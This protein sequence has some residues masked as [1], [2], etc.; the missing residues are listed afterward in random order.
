MCC[1]E[2]ALPVDLITKNW[3]L[4]TSPKKLAQSAVH[5]TSTEIL[6]SWQKQQTGKI[7]T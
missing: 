4:A 6:A 1:T 2:T 7:S 5:K 3:L